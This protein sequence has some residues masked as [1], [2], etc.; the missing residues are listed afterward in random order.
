[1][2]FWTTGD[3]DD[4]LW[5]FYVDGEAHASVAYKAPQVCWPACIQ[6]VIASVREYRH[7]IKR[8]YAP[9]TIRRQGLTSAT[10]CSGETL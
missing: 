7:R 9:V 5:S 3:T 2:H 10:K 8:C 6:S 1:M 4:A